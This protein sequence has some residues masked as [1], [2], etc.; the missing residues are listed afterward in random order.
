MVAIVWVSH[1]TS[2]TL[3][4]KNLMPKG[5]VGNL[6]HIAAFGCLAYFLSRALDQGGESAGLGSPTGRAA[7][8]IAAL[9]GLSDEVHQFFVPGRLCSLFDAFLD[10][11]GAAFALV[12]PWLPGGARPKSALSAGVVIAIAIAAALMTGYWRPP[13]DD[14]LERALFALGF[15]RS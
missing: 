5:P 15:S 4:H 9:F 1:R 11:A 2:I 3:A 12:L 7:F 6:L 14:A 13:A 8:L 10:A